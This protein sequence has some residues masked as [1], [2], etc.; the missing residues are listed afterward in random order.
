MS[1]IIKAIDKGSPADGKAAAPGDRLIRIN[2]H[3]IG[4]VLDYK[5]YA[6]DASLLLELRATDGKIKLVRV[7]KQ[8]G[9]DL[10]LE[11]ET[12]LMDTPRSCRN[13]CVFCF[14]DQLPRGMRPTLYYKDD[15]IRLSFLQGNYVTLTNLSDQEIQR[16]I[17]LRIQPLNVSVHSTEP[18]L[19]SY[20][21]G[22]KTPGAGLE[23]LRRFT[24]AKLML[25]CQIVVC[26]GLNDGTHLARTMADLAGMAPAV[27]SVS[28][29]PVGLTKHRKGL[30][31]LEPFDREHAFLTVRQIERFGARCMKTLG[32]R[33]VYPADELFLK[34]GLPIPPD[35]FYEEYPQLENGVG[36]LRL[37]RTEFDAALSKLALAESAPFSI[38]TGLGVEK[39]IRDMLRDAR[40][41]FPGIRG[42]VYGVRN[43]FFG[44]S[45]DVAGLLTGR[46]LLSQLGGKELG[47]RLLLARNMFRHGEDVLL[48]GLSLDGLSEEL[49]VPI[50]VVEQ[51]GGDL[52]RA[53]CGA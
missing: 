31:G 18:E 29:V 17:D 40:M 11:F 4:D 39:W 10:G 24:D 43:D 14:I 20:L 48:D 37:L 42:T 53:V 44:P 7:Y 13:R 30:P 5:Y 46:D 50:R 8:E 45:V 38:A 25:N 52:A 49:G 35:A 19:H 12:Y 32:T 3:K 9:E 22:Q 34:A 1:A 21:L 47:G 2:G 28:V 23:A 6:G 15:D 51:D 16:I 27:R 26:P 36:L 41:K 33:L